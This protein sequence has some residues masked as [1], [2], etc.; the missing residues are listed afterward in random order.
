MTNDIALA[1]LHLEAAF[2]HLH[3]DDA[4]ITEARQAVSLLIDA[5]IGIEHS[6]PAANVVQFPIKKAGRRISASRS[7]NR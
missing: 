6:R 2:N 1:R 5:I 3:G 7:T 4:F